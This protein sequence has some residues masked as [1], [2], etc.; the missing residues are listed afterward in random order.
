MKR[1][2]MV[3][4]GLTV[5]LLLLTGQV[6]AGRSSVDMGEKLFGDVSLGGS[7]NSKNCNNCHANGKGLQKAAKSKKIVKLMNRC[8]TDRLGGNKIDGRSAE[9]RSLKMYIKSLSAD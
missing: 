4:T 5:G 2:K 7:G 6:M 3:V 9:M 1:N 8:I